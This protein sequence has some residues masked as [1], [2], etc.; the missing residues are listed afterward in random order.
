MDPLSRVVLT[1]RTQLKTPDQ[2]DNVIL[3]T[4]AA[5]SRTSTPGS[6]TTSRNTSPSNLAT[7]P[8]NLATTPSNLA[9]TPTGVPMRRI[10]TTSNLGLTS[11]IPGLSPVIEEQLSRQK[12][13][14]FEV[15]DSDNTKFTFSIISDIVASEGQEVGCME[16]GATGVQPSIKRT[17]KAI[18]DY[19][20]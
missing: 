6:L 16:C 20:R 5:S 12:S 19:L 7:T 18:A 1:Q 4:P 17:C 9:T 11:S 10:S 8:N 14:T 2:L 15:V 3:V 13:E